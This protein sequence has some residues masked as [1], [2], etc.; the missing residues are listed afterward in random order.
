MG[1]AFRSEWIPEDRVE[2]LH[3]QVAL[4]LGL[5]VRMGEVLERSG[6]FEGVAGGVAGLSR[7]AQ[8]TKKHGRARE[9]EGG[10][11]VAVY[12]VGHGSRGA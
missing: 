7:E 8:G 12:G 9:I 3:V 11:K 2:Q 1:D 10:L 5:P 6:S 4:D